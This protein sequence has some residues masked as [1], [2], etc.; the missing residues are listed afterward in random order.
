MSEANKPRKI[1]M[2]RR[3]SL[4]KKSKPTSS[5]SSSRHSF[6]FGSCRSSNHQH[7]LLDSQK[8]N[9]IFQRSIQE[10]QRVNS[11]VQLLER[12]NRQR[13][14]RLKEYQRLR[15]VI[16]S[17]AHTKKR[18]PKVMIVDEAVRYI[19]HLH[20][21]FLQRLRTNKGMPKCL[22][23]IHIDV[24]KVSDTRQIQDLVMFCIAN[25]VQQL[26]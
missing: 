10:T 25:N 26:K 18:V 24:N 9:T 5:S 3:K 21:L 15:R 8:C 12:R 19:D 11:R 4:N 20:S 2:F 14:E 1:K 16:P 17:I 13:I 7:I 22:E 23:N 6:S